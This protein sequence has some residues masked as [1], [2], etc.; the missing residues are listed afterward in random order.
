MIALLLAFGCLGQETQQPAY[1]GGY[2]S[3]DVKEAYLSPTSM[4]GGS[5]NSYST[6]TYIT[7]E[8]SITL[9]V[10]EGML[11]SKFESVKDELAEQGATFSNIN[12]N[13]Y[14][15][16]KEYSL[17]LKVLPSKFDS[18]LDTLKQYGEVKYVSVDLE[19]VTQD[20][21]DLQT[22]ITNKEIEL[23]RLRDLYNK[24]ANISDLL[25]IEQE[26]TRVETEYDILK[27]QKTYLDSKINKST[28]YLSMYEDKPATQQLIVPFEGL[29]NLFFG[30]LAAAVAILVALTGFIIPI[31]IVVAVLWF[32]YKKL[33]G[34][35]QTSKTR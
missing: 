17:T 12:Y 21:T 32:V 1:Q 5:S 7:K 9:K 16:K 8:G 13:E 19:D 3:Y 29:G 25:S 14:S 22:R 15:T 33:K 11:E 2:N 26:L 18:V 24:S 30:A 20:Y 27:Q 10:A 35:S 4:M 31:A 6:T 28:I 34:R 23:G